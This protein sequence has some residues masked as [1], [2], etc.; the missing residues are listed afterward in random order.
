VDHPHAEQRRRQYVG[1]RDLDRDAEE[2][3]REQPR[4]HGSEIDCGAALRIAPCE[5]RR[6]RHAH[7]NSTPF[8]S[9]ASRIAA[10]SS[11]ESKRTNSH[12]KATARACEGSICRANSN[13]DD[14]TPTTTSYRERARCA[15]S[16]PGGSIVR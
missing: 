4:L 15:S 14:R 1:G 11:S 12:P 7:R 10:R 2:D 6:R 9:K 13:A 3:R 16:A 8:A 5:R